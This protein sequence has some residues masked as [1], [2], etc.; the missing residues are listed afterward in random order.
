MRVLVTGARGFVGKNLTLALS[1]RAGI[2]VLTFAR[3]ESTESLVAKI[4]DADFI[5]HLAGVNRPLEESE[6]LGGNVDLTRSVC[7]IVR[8]SGRPIPIIY[9][10]SI[11]AVQENPYGKSKRLAEEELLSLEAQTGNPVYIYRLPNVFGKWCRPNYNSVVATFCHNISQGLPVR[12]DNAAAQ[13]SLVYV[14]DVISEFIRVIYQRPLTSGHQDIQ[15]RYHITVGDL[16]KQIRKFEESKRSLIVERVGTGLTRALY[17]TYISYFRPEQFAYPL[18]KHEDARGAFVEMFK[19][20]DSGQASFFTARAGVTRGGHYHHTKTEKFL[21]VKGEARF[22]FCHVE[23][24]EVHEHCSNGKS[25]E[26]VETIP[27]WSHDI[28]NIGEDD[29]IVMLWANEIFDRERPD[30]IAC[31]V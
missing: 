5:C 30:T 8:A 1:E 13:L 6:F 19:T 29:M 7:D 28:T 11:Q 25:P 22:R 24:G 26:I 3:G 14:D 18:T 16:E 23:T 27:G 10:S 17:S 21:V 15:P 9:T 20:T 12:V 2:E 31:K 4:N